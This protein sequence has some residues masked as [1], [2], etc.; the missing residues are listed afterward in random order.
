MC[1]PLDFGFPSTPCGF[2]GPLCV[3]PRH[4]RTPFFLHQEAQN[5]AGPLLVYFASRL[6]SWGSEPLRGGDESRQGVEVRG[7]CAP[8]KQR[9]CTHHHRRH[10]ERGP[11]MPSTA[12]EEATPV[13]DTD[14]TAKVGSGGPL[15]FCVQRILGRWVEFAYLK[16]AVRGRKVG[17]GSLGELRDPSSGRSSQCVEW[18]WGQVKGNPCGAGWWYLKRW[19]SRNRRS[20]EGAQR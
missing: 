12:Q 6:F 16:T 19:F 18:G 7:R 9:H 4:S 5:S 1:L 13:T 11:H 3:S 2:G 15:A 10:D 17:Q 14:I 20:M 8:H